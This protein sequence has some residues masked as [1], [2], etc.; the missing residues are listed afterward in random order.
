MDDRS[1]TI[2]GQAGLG[3]LLRWGLSLVVGGFLII[4][5]ITKFAGGAHIF[6][7]IEMKALALGF[8][9]ADLFFPLVNY[10]TGTLEVVAGALVILPMTLSLIHI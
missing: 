5:G 1:E 6:P 4:M 2:V 10:A 3:R 8:P 7:L 9:L